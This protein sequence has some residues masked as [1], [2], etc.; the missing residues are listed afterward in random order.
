MWPTLQFLAD[1]VTF[2]EE[3]LNGKLSFSWVVK[4]KKGKNASKYLQRYQFNFS[5]TSNQYYSKPH[6]SNILKTPMSSFS[7]FF[8]WNV[9]VC[10]NTQAVVK[11]PKQLK[12]VTPSLKFTCKAIC[13]S[14]SRLYPIRLILSWIK[15][16]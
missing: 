9:F 16:M 15:A 4:G 7:L 6:W 3:I 12:K 1:I 14:T 13:Y 10:W 5:H 2:T 11:N 8:Y